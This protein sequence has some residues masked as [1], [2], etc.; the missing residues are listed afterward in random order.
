M[1]ATEPRILCVDDEPFILEL[2]EKLLLANGYV[3]TQAR[4]GQEAVQKL[5]EEKIDLVLLDIKMPDLDGFEVCR[6]IKAEEASMNIPVVLITG[7]TTKEDRIKGIEA[8][9]EDFISKPF[10]NT[11]ILARIKMLLKAKK[12]QERRIGDLLIEMNFITEEQLREALSISKGRGIKVGEALI[13]MGALDKDQI[14][15]VLSNQ[16]KMNYIDPSLETVDQEL[17]RQFP[18]EALEHFQCLPL[19]ETAGE[20]NFAIADPTNHENVKA[21]KELHPGKKARFHLA[22]PEKIG[23][24]LKTIQQELHSPPKASGSDPKF[25]RL[26]PS[27]TGKPSD[28]VQ[29]E[30]HWHKLAEFFFS[31]SGGEVGWL[32]RD[33]KGGR[34]ISQ[35][36]S[37]FR[38]VYQYSDEIFETIQLRMK[39][40]V[41]ARDRKG[42]GYLFLQHKIPHLRGIFKVGL[43]NGM[44]K[45]LLRIVRIP[46]F[47]L[48]DFHLAEPRTLQLVRELQ[49][50][51]QEHRRLLLGGTERLLIKEYCYSL[52]KMQGDSA[53]FP[54]PFFVEDEMEMY[55]PEVTQLSNY[56]FHLGSFLD[57][58]QGSPA[59]FVFYEAPAP[60]I[61]PD[62]LAALLGR[63]G[64]V[65]LHIPFPS[66][67]SM[68]KALAT[69]PARQEARFQ[70]AFLQGNQFK[71][72]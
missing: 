3:V 37:D 4:N 45:D 59:P 40:Q 65:I 28:S 9:A 43:L 62:I 53:A 24:I 6:R 7:L 49:Q 39:R 61:S 15:W 36:G 54:P 48:E 29:K 64:N 51:F 23:A 19:Y 25:A 14:Y 8:G 31:M 72:M 34:F 1:S 68:E 57:H 52:L 12:I 21:I 30:K 50:L 33:S 10:D 18:L 47:S 69:S 70:A 56:H 35:K 58:F 71:V 42:A 55:F 20:I 17:V 66:L 46:A 2:L 63:Y 16:L 5:K 27:I 60:E 32:Y 41:S 44:G 67:E 13:A 26:L 38:T 22:L 11:E